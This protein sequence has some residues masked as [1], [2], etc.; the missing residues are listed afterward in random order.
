MANPASRRFTII[1]GMVLVAATAVGFF[2]AR[3]SAIP[4]N[5][6]TYPFPVRSEFSDYLNSTA[7]T[8]T[9]ALLGLSLTR[10]RPTTRELSCRP[11]FSAGTAALTVLTARSAQLLFGS[12]LTSE[13]VSVTERIKLCM[14]DLFE[15]AWFA[16][17]LS[18]G[19]ACVWVA[20]ALCGCWRP[21]KT[22]L[23]R[24]GRALG[25]WWLVSWAVSR[26]MLR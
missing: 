22:W 19:V 5:V 16:Y 23:D 10:P 14:K 20:T 4:E 7:L 15:G 24:T 11:G 9:F 3:E 2:L 21:E 6:Q 18:L 17:D 26:W 8:W 13:I 12:S 25:V 1:D